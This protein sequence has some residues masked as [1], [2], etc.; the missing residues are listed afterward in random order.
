MSN[1]KTNLLAGVVVRAV[2]VVVVVA[3]G[4][5]CCCLKNV[6]AV[7]LWFIEKLEIVEAIPMVAAIALMEIPGIKH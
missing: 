2:I 7:Q 3:V 1:L 6:D 5:C 4:S